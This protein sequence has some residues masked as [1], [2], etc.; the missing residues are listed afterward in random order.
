LAPVFDV[1]RKKKRRQSAPVEEYRQQHALK[2]GLFLV[3][4]IRSAKLCVSMGNEIA[5]S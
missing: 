4:K 2:V 5:V 1:S 3:L